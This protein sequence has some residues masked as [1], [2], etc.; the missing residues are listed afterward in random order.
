MRRV[1]LSGINNGHAQDIRGPFV[2]LERGFHVR[3][4]AAS[5]PPQP[6]PVTLSSFVGVVACSCMQ[7]IGPDP[8]LEACAQT[9]VKRA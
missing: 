9:R 4:S 6:P 3:A 7:E 2:S 1:Q 5:S 8:W